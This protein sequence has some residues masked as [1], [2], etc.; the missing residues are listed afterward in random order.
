MEGKKIRGIL[1][2]SRVV[3]FIHEN[4]TLNRIDRISWPSILIPRLYAANLY[5]FYNHLIV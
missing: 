4:V 2:Q 5:R 3:A 1:S